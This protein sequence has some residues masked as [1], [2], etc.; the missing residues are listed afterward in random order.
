[1][2]DG[3]TA[4]LPIALGT[5]VDGKYRI[6]NVIGEGGMGIVVRAT[7]VE[8]ARDVALKFLRTASAADPEFVER[9]HRE[10]RA[11]SRSSSEH[12]ARVLDVGRLETGAPYMVMEY[13]NGEDLAVRHARCKRFSVPEAVDYLLQACE[14]LREAHAARIVHRDLKPANLFAAQMGN[15]E[16]IKVLDFGISKSLDGRDSG[17][18]T[19][20]T[21]MLGTALYMAPEQLRKRRDLDHR[22]DIWALGVILYEFLTGEMPF[23]AD[24]MPEVIAAIMEGD[25]AP[26][27]SHG[28]AI[29][30]Q[31]AQVVDRCLCLD[32]SGRFPDVD[33]FV[34]ALAPF[35]DANHSRVRIS[36]VPTPIGPAVQLGGVVQR[37][38]DGS[39]TA[40][41][42]MHAEYPLTQPQPHLERA[43]RANAIT[44]AAPRTT[45]DGAASYA[46]SP[47]VA[48][49]TALGRRP[50][51]HV[52]AL[53]SVAVA[54][55]SA[56]GWV[57]WL[58][59][60]G[61]GH[62]VAPGAPNAAV[63]VA[64]TGTP[65]TFVPVATLPALPIAL[66][67]SASTAH[68]VAAH[69]VGLPALG[70]PHA[71]GLG[72][73]RALAA[74][75]F[76]TAEPAPGAGL[77]TASPANVPPHTN[78]GKLHTLKD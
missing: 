70:S 31:L 56:I 41:T 77:T 47:P 64:A 39:A 44:E 52:A 18:L 78:L 43:P 30:E 29:P 37:L 26:I 23:W 28:V 22:V 73:S 35:Q 46:T 76:K 8:L 58:R 42:L 27:A 67:A 74:P 7:H 57:G 12:V 11:A 62:V 24:T 53:A 15:R 16:V 61:V 51:W 72:S 13:L 59:D 36:I 14:A 48:H 45:V 19:Q 25:A 69:S 5:L 34:A 38:A 68:A 71:A 40:P 54:V 6:D 55:A 4:M 50:S 3:S 20:T 17:R 49:G 66:E 63:A 32:A 10:A 65:S 1:M 9:F 2:S 21:T 33:A 60:T 75:A